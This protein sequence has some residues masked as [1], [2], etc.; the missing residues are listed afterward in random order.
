MAVFFK[1]PA[2]PG[3]V[4]RAEHVFEYRQLVRRPA[5]FACLWAKGADGRLT[6]RWAGRAGAFEAAA[7][8]RRLVRFR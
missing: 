5:P 2:P 3:A 7:E 4:V 8:P 1:I 6:G